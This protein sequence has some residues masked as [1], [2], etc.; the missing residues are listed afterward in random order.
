MKEDTIKLLGKKVT[1]VKPRWYEGKFF[2]GLMGGL[3]GYYIGYLIG[4]I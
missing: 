2:W 1:L 3:P 4:K